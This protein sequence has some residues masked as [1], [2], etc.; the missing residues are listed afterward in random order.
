M[1][2]KQLLVVI[3]VTSGLALMLAWVIERTQIANFMV[4]FDEW[5]E[6]KNG[7]KQRRKPADG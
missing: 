3:A 7:S 6:A 2:T 5:W 4:E 1:T